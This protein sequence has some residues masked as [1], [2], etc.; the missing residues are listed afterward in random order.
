MASNTKE[1][2]S[3]ILARLGRCLELIPIDPY[4]DEMS[5]GFYEKEGVITVWSFKEGKEVSERLKEIRNRIVELGDL[6]RSKNNPHEF[7]FPGGSVYSRAFKFLARNSVE[8]SPLTP[9][10]HG[11]IE[12]KDLKSNMILF[13]TPREE[14]GSWIYS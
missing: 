9:I 8:K 11:R 2:V 1:S 6:A 4:G 10:P 5:V 7:Y 13:A 14:N 12:V 3:Q